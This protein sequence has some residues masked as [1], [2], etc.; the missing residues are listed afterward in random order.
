MRDAVRQVLQFQ[1]AAGSPTSGH[2]VIPAAWS[3]QLGAAL[4]LEEALETIKAMGY[5]VKANP[6]RG[7]KLELIEAHELDIVEVA[8]GIA[9]LKYVAIHAGHTWGIP[10]VAVWDAVQKSNMAKFAD[11]VKRRDDG[12]II[13]P[14]GWQPPPIAKL[15]AES[16]DRH[17]ANVKIAEK[18]YGY[19]DGCNSLLKDGICI[20]E[21]CSYSPLLSEVKS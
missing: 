10:M 15:I 8:D 5:D 3:R 2:P 21:G 18:T 16:V 4:I 9:D 6:A 1:I 13:K 17:E 19:C 20:K 12:K 14:E 11:G 7:G